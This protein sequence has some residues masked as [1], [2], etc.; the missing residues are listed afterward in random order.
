MLRESS[1]VESEI[2][3]QDRQLIILRAVLVEQQ[4]R[5]EGEILRMPDVP[6]VACTERETEK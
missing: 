1:L 4:L 3:V 6:R 5:E 2:G